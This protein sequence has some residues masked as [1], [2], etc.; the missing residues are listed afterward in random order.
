MTK[1]LWVAGLVILLQGT[2]EARLGESARECNKRYGEPLESLVSNDDK[3]MIRTYEKAGIHVRVEFARRGLFK[4]FV[5]TA[6][7][8]SR[9]AAEGEAAAPLN[10]AEVRQLLSANDARDPWEELNMIFEAARGATIEE[11]ARILHKAESFS[12]WKRRDGA[13]AAFNKQTG[14]LALRAADAGDTE[15]SDDPEAGSLDGF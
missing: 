7:T 10:D 15:K 5:A 13:R 11:Q 3:S 6:I 1:L 2:C 9:A 12:F 14:E 4:R 8:Y